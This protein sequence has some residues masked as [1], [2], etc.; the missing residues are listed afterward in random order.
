MRFAADENFN[1][2]L[3]KQLRQRFPH[4][5]IVRVQDTAMYQAS[6]PALLEWAA[7]EDRIILTHDVQTLV[8]YAYERVEQGLPML[9]VLL[10]PEKLDI[11]EALADL[12]LAIGAGNPNDFRDQVTFIPM[13]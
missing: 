5:D 11:G 8:G 10:I 6:D 2:T 7:N 3:L 4:L 13:H 1:G 12:E 9:G